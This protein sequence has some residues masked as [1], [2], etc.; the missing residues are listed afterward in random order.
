MK[1]PGSGRQS[2]DQS[3]FREGRI[4]KHEDRDHAGLDGEAGHGKPGRAAAQPS[5]VD[6]VGGR[7]IVTR[8]KAVK[9]ETNQ[10]VRL[11]PEPRMREVQMLAKDLFPANGSTCV[12]LA[13]FN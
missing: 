9:R 1:Q 4:L 13:L 12:A 5:R 7:S 6:V 2:L 8:T 11:E 10:E 3:R